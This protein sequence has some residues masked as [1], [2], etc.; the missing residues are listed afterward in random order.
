[1]AAGAGLAE[2]SESPHALAVATTI[3]NAPV[4]MLAGLKRGQCAR[5]PTVV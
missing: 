2:G 3:V 4:V 1:M 5:S